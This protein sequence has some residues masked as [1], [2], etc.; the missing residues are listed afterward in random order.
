MPASKAWN[1]TQQETKPFF[2]RSVA[3]ALTLILHLIFY[4]WVTIPPKPRDT[5]ESEPLHVVFVNL[6]E[7]KQVPAPQ[8]IRTNPIHVSAVHVEVQKHA[9]RVITSSPSDPSATPVSPA[10][11]TQES[12]E[13]PAIPYG[14]SQFEQ[15]LTRSHEDAPAHIPGDGELV[16]VAGIHVQ[17]PPS[18][19]EIVSETG[20]VL[21][22]KDAIFKSRMTDEELAKRGLTER[23]MLM[24]Y[25]ELG[26]HP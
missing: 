12:P 5:L 6:S 4:I 22:C 21:N 15:A 3:I 24:K 2:L 7:P 8:P 25:S 17:T 14:N 18:I 9:V 19:S 16:K 26:C 23:Q 11:V 13:P 1:A 10:P 20:H